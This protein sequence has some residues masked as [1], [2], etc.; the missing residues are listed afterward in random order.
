MATYILIGYDSDKIDIQYENVDIL[1]LNKFYIFGNEEIEENGVFKSINDK[2]VLTFY[3]E[4][5]FENK[6]DI[7]IFIDCR[8][9][10]KTYFDTMYSLNT[11]KFENRSYYVPINTKSKI[12]VDIKEFPFKE[13]Y[14]PWSGDALPSSITTSEKEAILEMYYQAVLMIKSFLKCEFHLMKISGMPEG[15]MMNTS[16]P[17]LQHIINYYGLKSN[18]KDVPSCLEFSHNTQYR[19][20]ITKTLIHICSNFLIKNKFVNYLPDDKSSDFWFKLQT[21]NTIEM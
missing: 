18:A 8:E 17:I 6:E 19:Q 15:W 13:N 16:T 4:M 3:E 1:G 7:V 5:D 20:I 10:T 2:N 14:N 21:W 11:G 12:I 9:T